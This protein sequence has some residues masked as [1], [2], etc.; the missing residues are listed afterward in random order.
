[1]TNFTTTYY[2]SFENHI[3][4]W[5]FRKQI[6]AKWLETLKVGDKMEVVRPNHTRRNNSSAYFNQ[7]ICEV[8]EIKKDEVVFL[9]NNGKKLHYTIN[10]FQI[11]TNKYFYNIAKEMLA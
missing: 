3:A 11:E 1:M 10:D 4:E 8:V 9:K 6:F 2:Q 7:G 5:N